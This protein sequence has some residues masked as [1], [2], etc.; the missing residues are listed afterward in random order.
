MDVFCRL[1]CKNNNNHDK[2]FIQIWIGANVVKRTIKLYINVLKK[3]RFCAS[4]KTAEIAKTNTKKEKDEKEENKTR[5]TIGS[6]GDK[7]ISSHKLQIIGI[8]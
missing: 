5:K 8:T 6:A 1:C 4:M 2:D 3:L 7:V